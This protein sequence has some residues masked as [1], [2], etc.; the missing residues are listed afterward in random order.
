[1]KSTNKTL[2]VS[3]IL[4]MIGIAIGVLS[5]LIFICDIKKEKIVKE[6]IILYYPDT[7]SCEYVD[8]ISTMFPKTTLVMIKTNKLKS[9]QEFKYRIRLLESGNDYK[10]VKGKHLGAYQFSKDF[11]SSLGLYYIDEQTLLANEE[12]QDNI[13]DISVQYYKRYL[14]KEIKLYSGTTV[15]D[16]YIDESVIIAIAH[17]CGIGAAM[18]FFSSSGKEL[19]R[20][21]NGIA[22]K[23]LSLNNYSLK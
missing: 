2:S 21:G 22:Y 12:L 19:P 14:E 4:L 17:N 13:F 20:D 5:T 1:M 9:Y 7:A 10:K 3:I 15:A 18:K 16:Y 8:S 11:L 23:Y 6:P